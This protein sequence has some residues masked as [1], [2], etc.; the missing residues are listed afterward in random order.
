[1]PMNLD[2]QV[3]LRTAYLIAHTFA[4]RYW[5]RGNRADSLTDFLTDTGPVLEDQSVDPAQMGDW[6]RVAEE[7]L[8]RLSTRDGGKR[9]RKTP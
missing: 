5:E 1:M 4:E 6:L 8:N 7:V 2:E 3:T 9:K